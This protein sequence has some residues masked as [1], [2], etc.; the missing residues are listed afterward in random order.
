MTFDLA[1][2]AMRFGMVRAGGVTGL[3]NERERQIAQLRGP[4]FGNLDAAGVRG[5][6]SSV[7]IPFLAKYI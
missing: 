6:I 4:L 5:S 2:N 1:D 3:V 7:M